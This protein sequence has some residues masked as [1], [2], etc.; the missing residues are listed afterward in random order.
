MSRTVREKLIPHP[1]S[2][3]SSWHT[4]HRHHRLPRDSCCLCCFDSS[5]ARGVTRQAAQRRAPRA[6]RRGGAMTPK[7][8]PSDAIEDKIFNTFRR[9]VQS[10]DDMQYTEDLGDCRFSCCFALEGRAM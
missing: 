5:L 6:Q 10:P 3:A 7:R 1:L 9:N 8:K 2:S 4:H